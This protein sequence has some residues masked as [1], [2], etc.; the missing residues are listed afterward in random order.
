[1]NQRLSYE[2]MC[3]QAATA[4]GL[5]PIT[6]RLSAEG[7]PHTI[8][9]TGGFVMVVRI[10]L[11]EPAWIG[12]TAHD[13]QRGGWYIAR[14]RDDA[15][16]GTPLVGG[17]SYDWHSADEAVAAI[18]D[19]IAQASQPS[20]RLV[21]PTPEPRPPVHQKPDDLQHRLDSLGGTDPPDVSL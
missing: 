17:G 7:I 21:W 4:Q 5:D 19:R 12:V 13:D 11:A 2:E 20:R 9:Q 1:M 8:E 10:P 15:D 18:H 16:E 3:R 6:E 14:Y